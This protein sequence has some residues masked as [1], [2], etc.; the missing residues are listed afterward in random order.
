VLGLGS[1]RHDGEDA[2][3]SA[4]LR[5]HR[6]L[7]ARVRQQPARADRD[8]ARLRIREQ[9][10][11]SVL[12]AVYQHGQGQ[13]GLEDRAQP[14]LPDRRLAVQPGQLLGA[15]ARGGRGVAYAEVEFRT[16]LK[17]AW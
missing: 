12:I 17:R 13:P 15:H 4:G 1:H 9:Y 11:A 2:A 7:P 14:V 3:G 10:T 6:V 16:H 8:D 5:V